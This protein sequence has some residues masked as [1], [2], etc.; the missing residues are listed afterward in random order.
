L[1][2]AFLLS[3]SGC[4]RIGLA[5]F[6][7]NIEIATSKEPYNLVEEGNVKHLYGVVTNF[8]VHWF[9]AASGGIDALTDNVP[10]GSGTDIVCRLHDLPRNRWLNSADS[11]D[12]CS[13]ALAI[14]PPGKG[15]FQPEFIHWIVGNDPVMVAIGTRVIPCSVHEVYEGVALNDG[16]IT[17][18]FPFRM[19]DD[20]ALYE[21]VTDL[22]VLD[23]WPPH[24][25]QIGHVGNPADDLAA[26]VAPYVR[27]F[28]LP[29]GTSIAGLLRQ[30]PWT[31]T[32]TSAP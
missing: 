23:K 8:E 12:L 16:H 17:P 32:A 19:V 15:G 13:M 25:P 5:V 3:L 21:Q 27:H 28:Q 22:Y 14:C 31:H 2:L 10:N 18:G 29:T 24:G 20:P 11:V 6:T 7:K 4:Y 9:G 30:Q 1:L 26:M